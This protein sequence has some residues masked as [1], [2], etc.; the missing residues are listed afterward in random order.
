MGVVPEQYRDALQ[1]ELNALVGGQ[2]PELMTWV[3]AYPARLVR[4]PELIWSHPE[5][6]VVERDNGTA[7]GVLPLWT[8]DESPSDLS[9][10]FEIDTHGTVTISDVHVL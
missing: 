6:E 7:F 10:E 1:T 2:R 5:S 3:T 8:T 9:V 4:Q